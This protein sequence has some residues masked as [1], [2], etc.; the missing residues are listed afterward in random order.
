[1]KESTGTVNPLSAQGGAIMP[2][3]IP[4]RTNLERE[5]VRIWE[6]VLR[7]APIG[8]QEDFFDLGGTSIQAA[9]VFARIEEAFH[10]RL[11]LSVILGAQTIEKLAAAVQKGK[12]RD[13]K[14]KVVAIQPGGDKPVFVCI[15]GGVLWRPLSQHLGPHQPVLHVGLDSARAFEQL[16]KPKALENLAEQMVSALCEEQPQG[17]YYLGGFCSDAV[18]AYE[19]ARQLTM[20]GHE[21]GLLVMVEP[22]TPNVSAMGRIAGWLKRLI[23]RSGF[24]L[25]EL[26]QTGIGGFP[27]YVRDRWNGFRTMLTQALWRNSARFH[28]LKRQANTLDLD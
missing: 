12:S 6:E 24:R 18:F 8:I 7:S 21:I 1:M 23:F 26:R 3:P 27:Q 16:D 4:P 9:R 14:A 22:F 28:V 15:G 20:R 10:M 5:L 19:V 25:S 11:P 13:Q 17:P 2:T